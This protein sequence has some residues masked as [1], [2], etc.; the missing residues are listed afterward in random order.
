MHRVKKYT[1]KSF[2]QKSG[3]NQNL[4]I[5]IEGIRHNDI[6]SVNCVRIACSSK[7]IIVLGSPQVFDEQI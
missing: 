3:R 5:E 2:Y 7:S 1:T 6:Y 4:D